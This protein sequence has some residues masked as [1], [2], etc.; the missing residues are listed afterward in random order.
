MRLVISAGGEEGNRIAITIHSM[1]KFTGENV[2]FSKQSLI[3]NWWSNRELS[4]S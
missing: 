4:G 2:T 1:N 3:N